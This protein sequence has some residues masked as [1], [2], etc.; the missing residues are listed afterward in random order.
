PSSEVMSR[1]SSGARASS[2]SAARCR[3][4]ERSSGGAS[5]HTPE[6][7]EARAASTAASMSAVEARAALPTRA[8]VAGL[9]TSICRVWLPAVQR[10]PMNSSGRSVR[11]TAPSPLSVARGD[12]PRSFNDDNY[13]NDNNHICRVGS[14]KFRGPAPPR[15]R[16]P[17]MTA[18]DPHAVE[19]LLNRVRRLEEMDTAR[20]HLHRYA[21]TLDDP[22]P[23]AVAALFTEDG[24]LRTRRGDA[25]GRR[26]IA[27]FYRRLLQLDPAEK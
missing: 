6:S 1:A 10:P 18:T 7:K 13:E 11:D 25:V 5:A 15:T 12:S 9:R 27:E 2:R 4:A 26:G 8:P 19:D 14:R 3:T 21:E 22:T 23:E 17:A 20:N 24:V 16:R